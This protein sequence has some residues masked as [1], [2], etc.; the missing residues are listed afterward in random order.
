MRIQISYSKGEWMLA[1]ILDQKL[2]KL[3]PE[4]TRKEG[5][6]NRYKFINFFIDK[7]T[8]KIKP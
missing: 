1:D 6:D 8:A 4:A 2:Q 3:L 7:K 5:S